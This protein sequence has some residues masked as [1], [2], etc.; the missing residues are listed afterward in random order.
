MG[1]DKRKTLVLRQMVQAFPLDLHSKA[2]M[3]LP[4]ML[5][6]TAMTEKNLLTNAMLDELFEKLSESAGAPQHDENG[7]PVYA[8]SFYGT[9]EEYE[10][11]KRKLEEL[12]EQL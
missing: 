1:S 9:K 8:L 10:E 2:W 7:K 12:N 11:M 6:N 5:K 4:S 3:A